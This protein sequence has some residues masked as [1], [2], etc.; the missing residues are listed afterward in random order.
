[1][2]VPGRGCYRV[3]SMRRVPLARR[4]LSHAATAVLLLVA[5]VVSGVASAATDEAHP[6]VGRF[7]VTSD[8]G[9][10]VWTFQ[11]TGALVLIGPG[12]IISEGTWQPGPDERE[13]DAEVDVAVTGQ[14]LEV[15]GE[16]SPDGSSIA[17]HVAA[18]EP[19]RP[20][21]WTP[22]PA[23]SRLLGERS[24][25]VPSPEPSPTLPPPDCQRPQWIDGAVD[26]DRCDAVALTEAP[27]EPSGA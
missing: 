5:V 19:E 14:R 15:L 7:S 1:M 16:V 26:W 27:D 24:G 3:G 11:P 13:F 20:A 10:A 12:E 9:G 22:W 21:D 2:D 17:L 25:M 4:S 8:A 18:S 6:V 23:E